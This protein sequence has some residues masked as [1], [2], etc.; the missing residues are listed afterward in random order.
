VS[1]DNSWKSSSFISPEIAA[2]LLQALGLSS[3]SELEI[4][5]LEG[6]ITNTNYRVTAHGEIF[7][8]RLGSKGSELLGINREH[9]HAATAIAATLGIGADVI[10]AN[11]QADLL[12]TRFLAGQV[13]TAERAAQANTLAR[14]ADI[15]HCYHD[16][17]RFHGHFSPFEVVRNYHRLA[18]EY[19][20]DFPD[21]VSP[22]F[23]L[24]DTIEAA[25]GGCED[26]KPC[27]NDLLAANFIDNGQ[28]LYLIDW[29]YAAMGDPFFDLGNFAVNQALSDEACEQLLQYYFGEV[30][31]AAQARLKLMRLASDLRES[32]WGFLQ[33][34][35][36]SIDF[37]FR[38]YA[39][40]HLERFLC[41]TGDQQFP[42]LLKECQEKN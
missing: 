1:A 42:D 20:V 39:L 8:L 38:A 21:E 9:E 29:E 5:P 11:S 3:L 12:I 35:I 15:M 2:L 33:S 10:Y 17:P 25:I 41:A 16:G 6:G 26:L 19:R 23:A 18:I 24:S 4:R 36:S 7:V 40:H 31:P 34:G 27:H 28:H 22:A 30:K 14:V 32:F 13:L 37:D